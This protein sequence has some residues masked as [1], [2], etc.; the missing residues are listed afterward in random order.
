VAGDLLRVY[1]PIEATLAAPGMAATRDDSG[2]KLRR[3]PL[4]QGFLIEVDAIY[5]E[6]GAIL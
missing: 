4:G 1:E 5:N 6:S 3:K 2:Q